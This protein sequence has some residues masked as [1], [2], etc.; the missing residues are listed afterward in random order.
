ME[1]VNG[2]EFKARFGEEHELKTPQYNLKYAIGPVLEL[3]EQYNRLVD[4]A[5]Y[6]IDGL[7]KMLDSKKLDKAKL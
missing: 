7:H 3:V 6:E 1:E 4:D 5:R 2:G